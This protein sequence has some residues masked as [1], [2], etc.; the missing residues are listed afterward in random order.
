M[1]EDAKK[2][3]ENQLQNDECSKMK[4]L[5][6]WKIILERKFYFITRYLRTSL[7]HKLSSYKSINN[8]FWYALEI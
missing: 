6:L 2:K 1:I 3:L 7:E 8:T 4:L 5:Y